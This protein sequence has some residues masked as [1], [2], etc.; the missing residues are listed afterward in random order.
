MS[1]MTRETL[2]NDLNRSQAD[3]R[4]A[5]LY[6][7]YFTAASLG[8]VVVTMGATA[9]QVYRSAIDADFEPLPAALLDPI[10]GAV[11]L[12]AMSAEAAVARIGGRPPRSARVIRW[13]AGAGT[14]GANIGPSVAAGDAGAAAL[15]ALLP[16]ALIG[17]TEWYPHAVAAFD[18]RLGLAR[19]QAR[20][21][22][23]ALAE[24]DE[25]EREH[26]ERRS[27]QR[28]WDRE[29][30]AQLEREHRERLAELEREHRE[31]P[32]GSGSEQAEPPHLCPAPDA[33]S[34]ELARELAK[35]GP[36]SAW[37]SVPAMIAG[38]WGKR[39][40]VQTIRRRA[41]ALLVDRAA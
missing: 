4:R 34:D 12:L 15:H 1:P 35:L 29:R 23:R 8:L 17:M 39:S 20:A 26:R 37:P 9:V 33:S 3:V 24:L 13:F 6:R 16:L 30:Q 19:E 41:R 25:R 5:E 27:D 40:R 18:E 7:R 36:E 31:P 21:A 14:L 28:R 38:G 22:A 2:L 11:I 32:A 10:L